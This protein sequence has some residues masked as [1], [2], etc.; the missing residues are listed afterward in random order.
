MYNSISDWITSLSPETTSLNKESADT[1]CENILLDSIVL[2]PLLLLTY[3]RKCLVGFQWI[4]LS[5]PFFL[6]QQRIVLLLWLVCFTINDEYLCFFWWHRFV[7]QFLLFLNISF[8]WLL[9]TFHIFNF[10]NFLCHFSL[11]LDVSFFHFSWLY[12]LAFSLFLLYVAI[13]IIFWSA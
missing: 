3:R 5:K 7:K 10:D 2:L 1:L 12:D 4:L 11:L 8:W 6:G 9:I 13:I